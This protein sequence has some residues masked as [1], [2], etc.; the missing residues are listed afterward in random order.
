[1]LAAVGTSKTRYAPSRG[2]SSGLLTP[3]ACG[4][5][6]AHPLAHTIVLIRIQA[7]WRGVLC[8]HVYVTGIRRRMETLVLRN[9]CVPAP[10]LRWP[11][12]AICRPR[13]ETAFPASPA[14][15]LAFST[16]AKPA[17]Q[18][19]PARVAAVAQELRVARES[20]RARLKV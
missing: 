4:V 1:M 2:A 6:S 5:V 10:G 17:S 16:L 15:G 7:W 13:F 9:D 18:P 19:R 14:V 20:L 11:T 3:I 12:P 8:R